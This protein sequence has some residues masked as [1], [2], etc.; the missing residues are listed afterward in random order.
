VELGR[1]EQ[2][3]PRDAWRSEP[4]D[5]TP[6]L[7]DNA[8]NLGDALGIEVELTT[9]EHPVGGF[10]CDLIG[11]DLTNDAV[12]IV[13]NQLAPTDHTHLGQILTYAAGT[14]A[15]TVIWIAT[16]FREEHRQ[17]LDWLNENT[18][19][20]VRFFGVRLGLVRIGDSPAAPLL[21][22]VA[23]PNDWQKTIRA[24]TRAGP[25]SRE[26]LYLSFW[27]RYLERVHVEQPAWGRAR[28][29]VTA[30]WMSFTGPLPGTGINPSFAA[31]RRLRHEVYIDTGDAEANEE[32][33]KNLLD[34]RS[35]LES[36]YGRPLEFEAMPE[37]RAKRVAEY[38]EDSDV[39]EVDEYEA[40]IDWFLDAGVRLRRALSAIGLG[41][42]SSKA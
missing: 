20:D 25:S 8:V 3:D 26:S 36:A 18:G 21:D 10:S 13:E 38:R 19:E 16:N 7:L 5:F 31:G 2:L 33:F 42:V 27:T 40:Y 32:V 35:E 11:R 9:N 4:G 37:R 15:S 6:W 1:L 41:Q 17:A 28:K 12:L 23:Q 29:P 30:N 39:S 22:L 14:D 34:H 24:A